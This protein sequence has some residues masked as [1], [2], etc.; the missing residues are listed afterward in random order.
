MLSILIQRFLMEPIDD[1]GGSGWNLSMILIG[2]RRFRMEPIDDFSWNSEVLDRTYQRYWNSEL[3]FGG[4]GCRITALDSYFE[5]PGSVYGY[6]D[7]IFVLQFRTLEITGSSVLDF[8]DEVLRFPDFGDNGFFDSWILKT[9][10]SSVLDFGD[11]GSWRQ[12]VLR[13][14]DFEDDGYRRPSLWIGIGALHFGLVSAKPF[15]IG[16]TLHFGSVSFKSFIL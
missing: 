8:G 16:E 7:K 5:G 14:L 15:H 2:I 11:E 3:E 1:F 9:T 4:P 13:F 12:R 10:G 6:P